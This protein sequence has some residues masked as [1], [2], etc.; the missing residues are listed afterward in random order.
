MS[1]P[2]NQHEGNPS[3]STPQE[4]MTPESMQQINNTLL[5]VLQQ[6]VLS[7]LSFKNI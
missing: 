3:E 6:M 1:H 2:E 4:T 5:M 7:I